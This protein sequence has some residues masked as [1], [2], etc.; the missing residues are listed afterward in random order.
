MTRRFGQHDFEGGPSM[1][2]ARIN[3]TDGPLVRAPLVL[4]AAE[5]AKPLNVAAH[6]SAFHPQVPL[7]LAPERRRKIRLFSDV[8]LILLSPS[9]GNDKRI[10]KRSS[11]RVVQTVE[12]PS[13]HSADLNVMLPFAKFHSL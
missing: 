3:A 12:G 6:R 9:E 10:V 4:D 11:C 5:A 13:I 7:L 8:G 2:F 1:S